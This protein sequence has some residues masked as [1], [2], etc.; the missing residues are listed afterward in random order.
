MP[1][2]TTGGKRRYY[3]PFTLSTEI[4]LE[5]ISYVSPKKLKIPNCFYISIADGK[6]QFII[7]VFTE[8][9]DDTFGLSYIGIF[10]TYNYSSK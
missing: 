5:I 7:I 8:V 2:E 4:P 6:V 3:L 9:N 10:F 1:S